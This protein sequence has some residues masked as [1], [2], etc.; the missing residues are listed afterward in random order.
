[1]QQNHLDKLFSSNGLEKS[2]KIANMQ[3]NHPGI[4]LT[5]KDKSIF[6][7]SIEN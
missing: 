6:Y 4:Y 5:D 2:A 1:M 3:F 7:G